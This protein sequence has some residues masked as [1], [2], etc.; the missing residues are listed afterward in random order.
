MMMTGIS[1]LPKNLKLTL[2]K[3]CTYYWLDR[4]QLIICS[5]KS[6][7]CRLNNADVSETKEKKQRIKSLKAQLKT[8]LSQPVIPRGISTKYITSGVVRDLADRLLDEK[9]RKL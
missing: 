9:T 8:L 3:T 7:A 6:F 1:E 2:M 4:A 5:N